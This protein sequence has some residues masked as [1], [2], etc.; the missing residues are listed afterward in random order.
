MLLE[1]PIPLRVE[2]PYLGK[3]YEY[4]EKFQPYSLR[5]IKELLNDFNLS[6]IVAYLEAN[7]KKPMDGFSETIDSDLDYYFDLFSVLKIAESRD[8][9]V[10]EISTKNYLK[11]LEN[12]ELDIIFEKIKLSLVPYYEI[13]NEKTKIDENIERYFDFLYRKIYDFS[14]EE[15]P[16]L[17]YD[18]NDEKFNNLVRN[19]DNLFKENAYEE[20][21]EI[22]SMRIKIEKEFFLYINNSNTFTQKE[23]VE[24][25]KLL[26]LLPVQRFHPYFLDRYRIAICG[27]RQGELEALLLKINTTCSK[28]FNILLL[29]NEKISSNTSSDTV[30]LTTKNELVTN[31]L[32]K[33][34]QK[35]NPLFV[36]KKKDKCFGLLLSDSGGENYYALSGISIDENFYDT[37]MTAKKIVTDVEKILKEKYSNITRKCVTLNQITYYDNYSAT[38]KR[39]A[40]FEDIKTLS[41]PITLQQFKIKH[42]I[43][44]IF[45]DSNQSYYRCFSCCEPKLL[46]DLKNNDTQLTLY[47]KTK[48]CLNCS[49][50]IPDYKI[51]LDKVF[52]YDDNKE[53][54]ESF[55]M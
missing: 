41:V 12:L 30:L 19:I 37:S 51:H 53:S 47:V 20:S 54:I 14:D 18:F 43:N 9:K 16:F 28:R 2:I 5:L 44:C 24:Y 39:G 10:D 7:T 21:E 15:N 52:F 36:G 38:D 32:K 3:L 45:K 55:K 34:S 46:A 4:E 33:I 23:K 48:P 26:L 17:T 40:R 29:K 49:L 13:L 31:E 11:N 22:Y 50:I 6:T 8:E 27:A 25:A 42:G 35:V 1:N